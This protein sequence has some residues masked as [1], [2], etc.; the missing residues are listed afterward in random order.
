MMAEERPLLGRD[1]KLVE[2]EAGADLKL[3]PFGDLEV[4]GDEMNLGQAIVHRIRTRR[5]ELAEIGHG[6][7]GSRLYDLLGE[8]NDETT[9][10]RIRVLVREA[11]AHE[12]RIREIHSLTVTPSGE[13]ADV[14]RI[15]I[16]VSAIGGEVP[17]NIVVPF[18]LEVV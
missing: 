5:G 17:L 10:E 6:R 14:V 2:G 11:L 7:Y 15:E 12:P 1:L 8:P 9:R 3:S 4:V 16:T 13:R 18:Y